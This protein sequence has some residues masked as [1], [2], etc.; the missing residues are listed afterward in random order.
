MRRSFARLGAAAGWLLVFHYLD[1]H[2]QAMPVLHAGGF[3]P[4]WLDVSA[5]A[6]MLLVVAVVIWYGLRSYPPV[7]PLDPNLAASLA[8]H[9]E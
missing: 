4:S 2:W 9:N 3:A 7:P 6:G 8:H 1:L 5:L